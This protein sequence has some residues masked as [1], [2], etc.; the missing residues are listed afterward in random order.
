[1]A[2]VLPY[3]RTVVFKLLVEAADSIS[4]IPVAKGSMGIRVTSGMEYSVSDTVVTDTPLEIN[5]IR[6]GIS[7]ISTQ[8]FL[9]SLTVDGVT[10]A[11]LPCTGVFSFSGA[12]D[13]VVVK[14]AQDGTPVRLKY[15]KA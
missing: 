13:K 2:K 5:N 3:S 1:M 4:R 11:D 14:Q 12:I 15:V 6:G 10:S 9:V 7:L 8:R